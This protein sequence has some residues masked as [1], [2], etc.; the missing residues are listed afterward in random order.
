MK[1]NIAGKS[2]LGVLTAV[3]V[4]GA[5]TG[6]KSSTKAAATETAGE[7]TKTESTAEPAKQEESSEASQTAEPVVVHGATGGSPKP[8][9]FVDTSNQLTGHNIELIKAVFDRLPQYKLELEVTDFPSI[10]AGLDSD[11]Y[12]IGVNNF[13]KN[14]KR[15]EKYLFTDPIFANEYVAIFAKD[16]DKAAGIETWADLAGLKTISQAG[17]NITT[18]LEN[19]N[20]ANPQEPILIE[21]SDEDLVLQIQDVEAGKYDFVLMDKPMFEYY[22]REFNFN[23]AGV[24]ISNTLAKDLM[25]EPFSYLIVSKGNETLVEDINKALKEVIQDG[26]SKE[27]NLKWFGSDYSPSY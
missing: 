21:Y 16:N 1:K 17:I 5:L 13:A 18:A 26:T 27:I 11:R 25:E 12:Q 3:A 4:L 10:F 14:E 7:T 2:I 15:K 19:Y 20:T 9:T 23:V 24:S 8:F 22:Q 6:C